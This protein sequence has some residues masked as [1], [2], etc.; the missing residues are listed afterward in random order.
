[1]STFRRDKSP[2]ERQTSVADDGDRS[3][4]RFSFPPDPQN[5]A[6]A[7]SLA[8]SLARE[9][10]LAEA[11]IEDIRL[12]VS[13]A[14][15]NALRAQRGAGEL[16]PISLECSVDPDHRFHVEVTDTGGG[17][18]E[19][20]SGEFP[21]VSHGEGERGG[22]GVPLMKRVASAAKFTTNKLGGTTVGLVVGRD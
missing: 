3:R 13:E 2:E 1:M 6:E 17:F 4:L 15:T 10:G 19:E 18:S 20:P 8:A 16:S 14:V 5:V 7:R 22:F 12:V 9:H 11:E 21:D